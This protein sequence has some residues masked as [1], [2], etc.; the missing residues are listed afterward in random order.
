MLGRVKPPDEP[1]LCHPPG[2]FY[3]PIADPQDLVERQA[4]IWPPSPEIVGVD[5]RPEEHSRILTDVFP[6]FIGEY[7][8]PDS[9]G[10]ATDDQS[11]YTNNS[12]FGWLDS[13]ALF[14]L[15]REWRP[16]RLIEVGSGFSS[17]LAADV[18]RR[19]LEGS[20]EITCVEPYPRPFLE[21]GI[22]G[23][24]S[25]VKERVQLLEP[26][27]FTERLEPGDVLFIDSS[28]VVKTGSD[29]VHLLFEVLPRLSPGVRVHFHDVFF[30]A[31]YPKS[32]AITENRSWNEQYV[33][34]AL[35][36]Y[37]TAFRV[38]FGCNYAF[39]R[40]PDLVSAALGRPG[41]GGGSFWIERI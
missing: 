27:F 25:L 14:V 10:D 20:C 9:E 32:W 39:T 1:I 8:Y 6:R 19:F 11:Y 21:R 34:R 28:H 23:V 41:F 26:S 40:F 15:L 17:L 7:D 16:K 38:A 35:L 29:V 3:S 13:R 2:H 22:P 18:N 31:D 30:P 12:Q 5:F 33:L 36:M 24:A 37:S 4:K